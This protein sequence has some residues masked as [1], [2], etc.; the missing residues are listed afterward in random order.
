[1][2][3]KITIHNPY[4][5]IL[6]WVL[7]LVTV[8]LSAT[9]LADLHKT[10]RIATEMQRHGSDMVSNFFAREMDKV[11]AERDSLQTLLNKCQ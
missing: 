10:N 7:I 8:V 2:S 1:M 11:K 5:V 9:V 6:F 3:D 4:P